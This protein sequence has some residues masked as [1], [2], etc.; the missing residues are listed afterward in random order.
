[1]Q[2]SLYEIQI[3][4]AAIVSELLDAG[5]EISPELEMAL[6]INQD[7]LKEKAVSYALRIKEFLGMSD[8]IKAESDRLAKRAASYKK[9]SDRLKEYI[10]AA[11]LQFGVDKIEDKL[12]ALSFRKSEAV[13]VPEEFADSILKFVTI[14]AEIDPEK[15]EA[16]KAEY[17]MNGLDEPAIPDV[18]ML[19]YFKLSASVD[20]AKI[21][22][23]L[24]EGVTVG[25]AMILTK[26]NLQIK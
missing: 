13:E 14:K 1:M 15:V 23:S 8:M 16:I 4:H 6:A 10:S 7:E 20:N 5:G 21:K 3:D 22:A 11:M 9:T 19:D 12:V 24:K 26:K 18:E 25:D 17:E 2:K